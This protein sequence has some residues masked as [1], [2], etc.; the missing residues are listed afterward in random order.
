M[1][2]STNFI[3]CASFVLC[4]RPSIKIIFPKR[5][6]FITWL[7]CLMPEMYVGKPFIT[8]FSHK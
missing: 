8:L 1:K 5:S 6:I 7:R 4:V 2:K 3:C